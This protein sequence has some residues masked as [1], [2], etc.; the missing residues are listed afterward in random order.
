[1]R[2]HARAGGQGS[3]WGGERAHH[4]IRRRKPPA[5]KIVE[6]EVNVS[7]EEIEES[8][9]ESKDTVAVTEASQP[10][11]PANMQDQPVEPAITA[12]H[13]EAGEE[14]ANEVEGE[15]VGLAKAL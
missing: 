14:P 15:D 4:P 11:L 7:P 10:E 6:E 9:K 2:H 3:H 5:G 8:N 1:L 12:G 13:D